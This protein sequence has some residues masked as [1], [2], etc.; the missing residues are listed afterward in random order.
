MG[1]VCLLCAVLAF[2]SALADA[3]TPGDS[4]SSTASAVTASGSSSSSGSGAGSDSAS[5]EGGPTS[6]GSSTE[7][8]SSAVSESSIQTQTASSNSEDSEVA[9]SKPRVQRIESQRAGILLEWARVDQA[10]GYRIY[11]WTEGG[12]PELVAQFDSP[13]RRS[14]TDTG[15]KRNTVYWYQVVAWA[16]STQGKGSNVTIASRAY[17][18]VRPTTPSVRKFTK[19]AKARKAKVTWSISSKVTGY[20][21]Q[22]STSA[23]FAKSRT[24]RVHGASVHARVLKKLKASRTYYV[25]I[26][27]Y[28]D[29][30]GVRCYSPWS[31]RKR[32]LAHHSRCSLVKVGKRAFEI[33]SAAKQKVYGYDTLQGSCSDGTYGYFALYNRNVEKCK[34]A[35]VRLRNMRIVKVSRVLD[36][37]HANGMTYNSDDRVIVVA[38]CSTDMG[39]L[40]MVDPDTL[41]VTGSVKP[42]IRAKALGIDKKTR[43]SIKGI[44]SI[45]YCPA[46]QQYVAL[47]KN[48]RDLLVLDRS[49]EPVRYLDIPQLKN[50]YYQGIEATGAYINL[51]V[52]PKGSGS[53]AIIS[54]SWGGA[55]VGAIAPGIKGEFEGMFIVGGY[56]YLGTYQSASRQVIK[57]VIVKKRIPARKKRVTVVRT[58]HGK[59]KHVRVLRTIP[60]HTKKTTKYIVVDRLLRNNYLYRA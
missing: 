3:S 60:A 1:L 10:S 54:Y 39:R 17:I 19:K 18:A 29:T 51:C 33:R 47:L 45:A 52:S 38:R 21:I 14:W 53:N 8:K 5:A 44:A 59:K 22:Y 35:K 46:R 55:L 4:A 37:A 50:C 48:N 31:K 34:I 15:A 12:T 36:V 49:F 43:A 32:V 27:S 9:L 2:D 58:V 41:K 56:S 26:R 20:Q 25:R 7:S 11:R 40:M 6:A 42:A 57:K 24:V 13:L 30:H 16:P 23:L 28:V